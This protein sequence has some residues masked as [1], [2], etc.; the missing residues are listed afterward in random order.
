MPHVAGFALRATSRQA[1]VSPLSRPSVSSLQRRTAFHATLCRCRASSTPT[2]SERE[3]A[4][5]C[6]RQAWLGRRRHRKRPLW[7]TRASSS[8]STAV[9]AMPSLP[10]PE[11]ASDH[12]QP[13]TFSGTEQESPGLGLRLAVVG[14]QADELGFRIAERYGLA[15]TSMDELM[16]GRRGRK[17]DAVRARAA[18]QWL[19]DNGATGE[20]QRVAV[21]LHKTLQH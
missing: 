9:M 13:S 4:W 11:T 10:T 20:R 3:S 7:A 12:H 2:L 6:S 14:A 16:Q 18:S 5:P 19:E 1:G 21:S 17:T 8:S 15:T